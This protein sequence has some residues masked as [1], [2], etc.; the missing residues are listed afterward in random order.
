MRLWTE[1]ENQP[2]TLSHSSEL[3]R[4][5]GWNR[6]GCG[7][8]YNE[9]FHMLPWGW[10]TSADPIKQ[11]SAARCLTGRHDNN[12]LNTERSHR[13]VKPRRCTRSENREGSWERMEIE[14]PK[15]VYSDRQLYERREAFKIYLLIAVTSWGSKWFIICVKVRWICYQNRGYLMKNNPILTTHSNI[16]YIKVNTNLFSL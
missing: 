15:T 16:T 14:C 3:C 1:R 13:C 4:H 9:V 6:F 11:P 8:W 7:S 2:R 12:L 5:T 10:S